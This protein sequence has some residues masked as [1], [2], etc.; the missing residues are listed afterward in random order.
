MSTKPSRITLQDEGLLKQLFRRGIFGLIRK[1][2]PSNQITVPTEPD[3]L[4]LIPRRDLSKMG[5]NTSNM[6]Y[7]AQSLRF[8][9]IIFNPFKDEL[10]RQAVSRLMQRTPLIRVKP[11]V[12]LA[13]Q[14]RA[15]RFRPYS[16]VLLRPSIFVQKL[17]ELG[18]PVWYASRLELCQKS[19][20]DVTRTL[21]KKTFETSVKRILEASRQLYREIGHIPEKELIPYYK[22]RFISIRNRLHYIRIKAIFFKNEL[23]IDMKYMVA[24]GLSAIS[25]VRQRIKLCDN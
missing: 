19:N 12:V 7:R 15:A 14:I 2:K 21:I 4:T 22:K 13:P 5:N 3:V 20:E 1:N 10:K 8:V 23:G 16:K 18:S 24:R 9:L 6:S 11:G 25:R 17:I